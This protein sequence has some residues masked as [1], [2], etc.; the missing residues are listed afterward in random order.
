MLRGNNLYVKSFLGQFSS[1]FSHSFAKSIIDDK[2]LDRRCHQRHRRKQRRVA[3][4]R[5]DLR[6]DRFRLEPERAERRLLDLGRPALGAAHRYFQTGQEEVHDA[7]QR[8][9]GLQ[10]DAQRRQARSQR[11]RDRGSG[12]RAGFGHAHQRRLQRLAEYPRHQHLGRRRDDVF[13]S[14]DDQDRG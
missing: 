3:I 2:P 11:R 9:G 5:D 6:G 1:S 7:G 4:T 14:G 8:A 10:V 13:R 12:G